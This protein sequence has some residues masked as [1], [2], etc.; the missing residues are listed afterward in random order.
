VYTH[1]FPGD[2]QAQVERRR[3][4]HCKGMKE[5]SVRSSTEMAFYLFPQEVLV[6]YFKLY[7]KIILHHLKSA[8]VFQ[9]ASK[10]GNGNYALNFRDPNHSYVFQQSG[11]N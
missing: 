2:S 11:P 1:N 8:D 4:I 3:K 6:Q 7:N 5:Y 10:H 9:K